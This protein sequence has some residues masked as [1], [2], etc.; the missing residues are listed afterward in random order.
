VTAVKGTNSYPTVLK[1]SDEDMAALN[2][3][4]NPFHGDWYY[5]IQPQ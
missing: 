3:T 1:V 5:T 2:T 4:S